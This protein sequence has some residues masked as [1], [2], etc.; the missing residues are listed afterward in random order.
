[1]KGRIKH[2]YSS[3]NT[4]EGYYS[5][6]ESLLSNCDKIFILK[7]DSLF[8]KSLIIREIGFCLIENGFNV[9]FIHCPF[10]NKALDGLFLG[11]FNILL[12]N[13]SALTSKDMDKIGTK[14]MNYDINSAL[15]FDDISIHNEE[16]TKIKELISEN[17][18]L[19]CSLFAD[20]LKIHDKWEDIY[21]NNMNFK[22]ADTLIDEIIQLFFSHKSL[23]KKSK[24]IHKFFGAS[25]PKGPINYIENLTEDFQK[26]FLIKGRPGSGKSTLL[27]RLALAGQKRGYDVDIYHCSFHP[28]SLDMI[29]FPELSIA[30]FDST[31]PHEYF[32]SRDNDEII[33]MYLETI[34]HGTDEKYENT[35][36]DIISKYSLKVKEGISYL[37]EAKLLQD[38][39][40]SFYL[41][42]ADYEKINQIKL[43]IQQNIDN[44][45]NHYLTL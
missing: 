21:I 7:C 38:R 34:A 17:N 43:K 20:A 28:M 29:L 40:E 14:K 44:A 4:S 9:D 15:N 2:F 27:K 41:D 12:V 35:L 3:G 1:M 22:K 45:I 36:K 26:R 10:D 13:N 37:L 25:T 30:I 8:I 31:S 24:V 11:S 6:Y 39:I 19:T 32:P 16:I 42:A 5:L 18:Q 23:P 33:D